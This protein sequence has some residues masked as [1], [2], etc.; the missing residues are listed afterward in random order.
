MGVEEKIQK[1]ALLQQDITVHGDRVQEVDEQ[2]KEFLCPTDK[3][4][5]KGITC[6]SR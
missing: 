1:H 3:G 2:S 4:N 6:S 5:S